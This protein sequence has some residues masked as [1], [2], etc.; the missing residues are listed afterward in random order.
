VVG[1]EGVERQ[2]VRFGVL[3][4]GGDLG[5]P[6]VKVRDRLGEPIAGLVEVLRVEDGADQRGEQPVLVALRVPEAVSEEPRR[7][8]EQALLAVIHT[9]PA[10]VCHP[11][12]R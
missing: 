4:H 3:E 11:R 7:R 12:G 10:R 1:R 8:S 2:D 9:V 6:A 5:E